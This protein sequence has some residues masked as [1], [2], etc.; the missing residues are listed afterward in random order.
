M[1]GSVCVTVSM[2]GFMCNSKCACWSNVSV[3]FRCH[4]Y[5]VSVIG[6]LCVTVSVV[7]CLCVT[8][9]VYLDY[10]SLLVS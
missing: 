4:G 8:V 3:R 10:V 1:I 5:S 2:I 7:V 9:S 6:C